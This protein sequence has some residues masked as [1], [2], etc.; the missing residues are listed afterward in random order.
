MRCVRE[1]YRYFQTVH[2]V[3]K[4]EIL[5]HQKN[6]LSNLLFSNLFSKTA[7][8]TTMR[9]RELPQFPHCAVWKNEKFA[10]TQKKFHQINSVVFSLVKT[11]LSRNFCQ[12]FRE[13][14][15]FT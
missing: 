15:G 11:V 13:N 10:V 4:R 9:E 3:V 14:N 12:K 1:N 8:F 5:S 2:S 7:T 6:I